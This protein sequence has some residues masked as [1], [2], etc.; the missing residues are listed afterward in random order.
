MDD[1]ELLLRMQ[2]QNLTLIAAIRALYATHPDR[3]A[4]IEAFASEFAGTEIARV[5]APSYAPPAYEDALAT[6]REILR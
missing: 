1:K 3:G 4:F 6:Y 2:G 5:A